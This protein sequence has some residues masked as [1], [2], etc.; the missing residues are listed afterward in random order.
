M[1]A[2]TLI[3]DHAPHPVPSGRPDGERL[4]IPLGDLEAAT[5]WELKPEGVCRGETCVPL[6]RGREDE[7]VRAGSFDITALA[8]YLDQPVVHDAGHNAW[9]IGESASARQESLQSLHA[10]D[11]T[12]P[13][14]EGGMHSL[15]DYRGRKVF[16]ASWASW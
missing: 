5:G 3:I 13:D 7:F 15:S 2:P 11:F 8:R 4:W 9:V 16:L 12:L 14:L 1:T 6:P 10:P